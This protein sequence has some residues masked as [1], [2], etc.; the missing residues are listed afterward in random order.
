MWQMVSAR[1]ASAQTTSTTM[2]T[3]SGA[4]AGVGSIA[5]MTALRPYT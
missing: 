3:S 2:P 5:S 4:R 1:A